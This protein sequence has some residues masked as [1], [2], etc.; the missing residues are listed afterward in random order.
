MSAEKSNSAKNNKLP[1][2][3]DKNT[4]GSSGSNTRE[5]STAVPTEK[6]DKLRKAAN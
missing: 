1:K 6:P 4:K 5:S 3:S 2:K